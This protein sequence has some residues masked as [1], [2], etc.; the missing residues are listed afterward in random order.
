MW[1]HNHNSHLKIKELSVWNKKRL[2]TDTDLHKIRDTDVFR[3]TPNP[4]KTSFKPLLRSCKHYRL[5]LNTNV[6][7]LGENKK[8]ISKR[9]FILKRVAHENPFWNKTRF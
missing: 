5:D 6:N 7:V 2:D 1:A 8:F 4:S 3:R 9:V